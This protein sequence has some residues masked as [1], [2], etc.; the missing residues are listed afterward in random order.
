MLIKC[1]NTSDVIDTPCV[2]IEQFTYRACQEQVSRKETLVS[3]SK[4]WCVENAL[5]RGKCI[6]AREFKEKDIGKR[7]DIKGQR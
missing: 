6:S 5:V 3:I 1:L 2:K 4:L 7:E